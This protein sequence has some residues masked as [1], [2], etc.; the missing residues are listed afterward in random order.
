MVSYNYTSNHQIILFCRYVRPLDGLKSHLRTF[1]RWLR[2]WQEDSTKPSWWGEDHSGFINLWWQLRP[3][4][5][6][7]C[8]SCDGKWNISAIDQQRNLKIRQNNF[9][10]LRAF[11]IKIPHCIDIFPVFQIHS[12]STNAMG[13]KRTPWIIF[14]AFQAVGPLQLAAAGCLSGDQQW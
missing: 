10:N 1:L 13:G 7:L 14:D 2:L 8:P 5:T 3:R 12:F 6:A 11:I 4:G 9:W